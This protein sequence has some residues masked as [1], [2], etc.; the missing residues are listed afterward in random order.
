MSD[1]ATKVHRILR[2]DWN[3]IGDIEGLPDDEYENYEAAAFETAKLSAMFEDASIVAQ[4]LLSLE[5]S[6]FG[7]CNYPD[8]VERAQAVAKKL[9]QAVRDELDFERVPNPKR[10]G[11]GPETLKVFREI[12]RD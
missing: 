7:G 4:Y 10:A 9:M 12:A 1:L 3:P 6:V 8:E 5:A 2:D 11:S